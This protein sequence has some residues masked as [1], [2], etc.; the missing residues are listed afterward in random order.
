MGLT[1]TKLWAPLFQQGWT[2]GHCPACGEVSRAPGHSWLCVPRV[3]GEGRKVG[4]QTLHVPITGL[5][6][7]S[8]LLTTALCLDIQ[9][10]TQ[11]CLLRSP[12]WT[13][14]HCGL[15]RVPG[16]PLQVWTRVKSS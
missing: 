5:G 11:Y 16:V 7:S 2:L 6:S 15:L 13:T 1:P 14:A 4:D 12:E 9:G 10:A 8:V 3:G